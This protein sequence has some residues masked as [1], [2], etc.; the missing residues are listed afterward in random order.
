MERLAYLGPAG[1]F[2][3]AALLTLPS[4]AASTHVPAST[5]V[6]ALDR[7]RRGEVDGAL[8]PLENSVE[9]AVATTVDDL[10][11]G[12]PLQ[13]RAEVLL[14]VRFALL[15]HEGVTAGDVRRVATHPH[16]EAQCRASLARLLPGAEVVPAASTAAAAATVAAGGPGAPG[17][18]VASVLAGREHGLAVLAD[19]VADTPGGVTRFVLVT[20]PGPLPPPTGA[21]RTTLAVV[22][23]RSDRP[24]ALVDVLTELAVRGVNLTRLES[25]P[26]GAGLGDYWFS[27]DA[28]G[29]VADARVGDAVAALH[30]TCTSVRVLGSYPR[31]LGS[32]AGRAAS[33]VTSDDAFGRAGTWLAAVRAGDPAP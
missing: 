17:A 7:V 23:P 3:H 27:L 8:V 22:P 30:R 5:V 20:R 26:T 4:A 6:D 24:G 2:S 21:D 25:R 12:S 14:P 15:V 16:A 13:L 11:S 19:D 29:H 9:G 10:S 33:D 1:T 28:D 32:P 18:A 31:A